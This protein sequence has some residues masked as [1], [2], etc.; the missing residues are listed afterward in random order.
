MTFDLTSMI[1]QIK[2]ETILNRN[3]LSDYFKKFVSNSLKERW[4]V[5]VIMDFLDDYM[6]IAALK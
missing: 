6:L 3:P 2:F 5:K 4:S 1:T